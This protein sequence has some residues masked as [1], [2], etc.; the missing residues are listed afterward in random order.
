MGLDCDEH[1]TEGPDLTGKWALVKGLFAEQRRHCCEQR[2]RLVAYAVV[3]VV[4]SALQVEIATARV[5]E[6]T[7]IAIWVLTRVRMATQGGPASPISVTSLAVEVGGVL[8][9]VP[10]IGEIVGLIMKIVEIRGV[11][12]CSSSHDGA[13]VLNLVFLQEIVSNRELCN[14]LIS[15]VEQRS[16]PILRGFQRIAESKLTNHRLID[17]KDD[18]EEY[19]RQVHSTPP[20]VIILIR[21]C[22]DF[23]CDI[24]KRPGR[25]LVF[26]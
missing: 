4:D 6:A 24:Y 10:Y 15:S 14:Q 7:W 21:S 23:L 22:P 26:I 16:T 2:N 18:L 17:M 3:A 25:I 5:P 8:E 20:P 1:V 11:S 9:Q 19:G 13:G 12:L